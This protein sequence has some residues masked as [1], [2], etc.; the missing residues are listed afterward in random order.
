MDSS[1]I[2]QPCIVG[3]IISP[4]KQREL[5]PHLSAGMQIPWKPCLAVGTCDSNGTFSLEMIDIR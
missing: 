3:N 5:F 4:E 2:Q 1:H